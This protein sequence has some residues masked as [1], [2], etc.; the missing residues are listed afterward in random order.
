MPKW[1]VYFKFL[2]ISINLI[3]ESKNA[4]LPP[5]VITYVIQN[6][7]EDLI[8]QTEFS[9]RDNESFWETEP[10]GTFFGRLQE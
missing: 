5:P 6:E 7:K 2:L 1:K 10:A 8:N 4:L 9:K 3:F